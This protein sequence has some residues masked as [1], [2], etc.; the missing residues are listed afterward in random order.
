MEVELKLLLPPA[1]NDRLRAHP[2]LA[3]Y[4]HAP[5][6]VR[7]LTAHYFDTPDLHGQHRR[8]FAVVQ[9]H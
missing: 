2:L 1:D 3:R 8:V 4:A 9:A 5:A 7:Q 6:Q